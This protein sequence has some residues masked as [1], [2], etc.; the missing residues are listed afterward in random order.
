[1][2]LDR[3]DIRRIRASTDRSVLAVAPA[4]NGN[5][6]VLIQVCHQLVELHKRVVA[7]EEELRLERVK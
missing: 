4:I 3:V 2:E 5:A 1:M 7:L 6:D